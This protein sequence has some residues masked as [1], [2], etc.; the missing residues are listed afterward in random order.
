MQRV[1]PAS[2]A[3]RAAALTRRSQWSFPSR[4]A[5]RGTRSPVCRVPA[6]RIGAARRFRGGLR[7]TTPSSSCQMPQGLPGSVARARRVPTARPNLTPRLLLARHSAR[8]R[9]R[10]LRI[11]AAGGGERVKASSEA[12][13]GRGSDRQSAMCWAG[14]G[15]R[16]AQAPVRAATDSLPGPGRSPRSCA[17][18]RSPVDRRGAL[19]AH[20]V[21]SRARP[22]RPPSRSRRGMCGRWPRARSAGPTAP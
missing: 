16:A 15:A 1:I 18:S 7:P 2:R 22:R 3:S 19:P 12:F 11:A 8:R 21:R 14:A 9:G 13:A 17:R 10:D 4:V 6:R 5:L 20:R